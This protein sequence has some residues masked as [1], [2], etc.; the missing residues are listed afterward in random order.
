MR[1]DTIYTPIDG[2]S[3]YGVSCCGGIIEFKTK[4]LIVPSL[5]SYKGVRVNLKNSKGIECAMNV[6]EIVALTYCYNPNLF[7]RIE[8]AD[9]DCTNVH[10]RNLKWI[11]EPENRCFG[12]YVCSC[13]HTWSS[14]DSYIYTT[15]DCRKCT[16][17][18]LP[19]TINRLKQIK[20]DK[21]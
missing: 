4:Q 9:N 18:N 5:S 3:N 10:F 14:A 13:L 19:I 17:A 16:D 21:H 11:P 15:Q 20:R 6:S 1:D 12:T 8:F 2:Y 7:D